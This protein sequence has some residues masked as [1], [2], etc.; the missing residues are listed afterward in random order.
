MDFLAKL[1]AK[2]TAAL[3][4]KKPA[5]D[6]GAQV[7]TL[8]PD[9]LYLKDIFPKSVLNVE[10]VVLP[11]V[12][13]G[14]PENLTSIIQKKDGVVTVVFTGDTAKHI[15]A[16][17]NDV[18]V[19]GVMLATKLLEKTE[20]DE[21]VKKTLTK[22]TEAYNNIMPGED[23]TP[24][25]L[26]KKVLGMVAV[27]L[28][29]EEAYKNAQEFYQALLAKFVVDGQIRFELPE[30]VEGKLSKLGLEKLAEKNDAMA[31]VVKLLEAQINT[32]LENALKKLHGDIT[33]H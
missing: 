28:K 24:A 7:T 21:A 18:S 30:S 22:L 32:V 23:L 31:V 11:S 14:L 19:I 4:G 25:Q 26:T 2:L 8:Y 6:V 12:E 3:A 27:F 29:K 5:V 1:F 10:F 20:I 13:G 17:S 15:A 33:V 9:A 16:A